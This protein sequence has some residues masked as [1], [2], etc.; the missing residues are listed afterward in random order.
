MNP[1]TDNRQ[2]SVG[3]LG[4]ENLLIQIREWLGPVSPEEPF[5]IGDDCAVLPPDQIRGNLMTVDGLFYNWHFD[6]STSAT[7]AGAK[8]LKRN[9]SDLAAM[10]G[11]PSY[12]VL[13]F[14]QPENTRLDWLRGFYSGLAQ[15]AQEW[16]V[17]ILGGD[18]SQSKETLG[19]YLTLCGYAERP[20]TRKGASQ[21]DHLFVTGTLGGSFR[22]KHV[23]FR[24][25]L[26][27]GR[28]LADRKFV[29]SMIDVTDGL[30]KDLPPLLPENFRAGIQ[31]GSLPISEDAREMSRRTGKTELDHALNDGEDYELLFTVAAPTDLDRLFAEWSS[32]FETQLTKIG[33]ILGGKSSA[34][35]ARIVDLDSGEPISKG[36]GQSWY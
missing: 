17:A 7:D 4:E 18:L 11:T 19:G 16:K 31:V 1:F 13:G 33:V 9:L 15:A 30:M 28:W 24:P 12:G 14:V 3:S 22:G 27:E 25:R 5:G 10:G 2:E 32:S 35:S 20:L 26:E 29:R 23:H 6:S 36:T 8:L 21:R 34:R